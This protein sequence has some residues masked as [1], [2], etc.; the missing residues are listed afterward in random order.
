[1]TDQSSAQSPPE[2]TRPRF[3]KLF[4]RGS[5]SQL[6]LTKPEFRK[7]A[8]L[9][10]MRIYRNNSVLVILLFEVEEGKYE[11]DAAVSVLEGVLGRYLTE[12]DTAGYARDGRIGVLLPDFA[13][14]CARELADSVLADCAKQG[15]EFDVE[16]IDREGAGGGGPGG[17]AVGVIQP[18]RDHRRGRAVGDQPRG[19]LVDDRPGGAATVVDL[20][21]KRPG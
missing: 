18:H 15:Y 9:E 21:L 4:Q 20:F 12:I 2:K 6:L 3:M 8:E 11:N 14:E 19:G 5:D 16:L 17:L 13:L 7:A 1:M 10:R